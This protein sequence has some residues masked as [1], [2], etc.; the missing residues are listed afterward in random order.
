[1]KDDQAILTD[2]MFYA[3]E[4]GD[5]ELWDILM[6][7]VGKPMKKFSFNKTKPSK[8]TKMLREVYALGTKDDKRRS[9]K[10]TKK[11]TFRR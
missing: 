5:Q 2:V 10:K 1:M 6:Q 4:K 7:G 11:S 8:A 3:M 9:T